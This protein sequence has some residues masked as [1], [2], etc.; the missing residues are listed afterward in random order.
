M[1]QAAE[2]VGA[3]RKTPHRPNLIGH[4]GRGTGHGVRQGVRHWGAKR[5]SRN[6]M[7]AVAEPY[8]PTR[9]RH[10]AYNA[11]NA[12]KVPV[13]LVDRHTREA[14]RLRIQRPSTPSL[15]PHREPYVSPPFIICPISARWIPSV[16][17]HHVSFLMPGLMPRPHASCFM[18]HASS[19][20]LML[21]AS[22]TE[23]RLGPAAD[24]TTGTAPI[25]RPAAS[26]SKDSSAPHQPRISTDSQF[27]SLNLRGGKGDQHPSRHGQATG[28]SLHR[29]KGN[30]SNLCRPA[31][32]GCAR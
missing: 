23:M 3:N 20:C 26:K 25:L 14:S 18:L 13:S 8:D 17:L 29:A 2:S 28:T 1:R 9:T 31:R 21:H 5:R 11:S 12:S 4:W 27:A 32:E 22:S 10:K 7:S 6:M 19:S 30:N 16:S 24:L 15:R